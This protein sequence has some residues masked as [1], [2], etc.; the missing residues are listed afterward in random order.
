MSAELP[1]K[2]G[3]YRV[4]RELGRGATSRVLLATDPFGNREVAIKLFERSS[5]DERI[6]RRFRSM[7]LNEAMLA[8]K[9]SHPYIASIYDA[10]DDEDA[11]YI[12]MEYVPG[13]TLEYY[14]NVA[15]LLPV[16][17]VV[18]VVFKCAQ[19]LWFAQQRGL[20]HRD[21]KP[22]NILGNPDDGFKVSDFGSALSATSDQT[23]IS[24]IGSPAFMSP[25]QVRD[26]PLTHQ[27]D[28]YSLG[29]VMY[30]LL[31]GRLPFA[32]SSHASL[33]YQILNI[34]APPPSDA[35]EGL[36]EDIDAIVLRAMAKDRT[37]RYATWQDFADDLSRL[38]GT[39]SVPQEDLNDAAK[40]ARV[41]ELLFFDQFA[42]VEIWEMLRVTRW[43][44]VMPG[45]T[46]I[47][48]GEQGDSFYVL[49]DGE[50]RVSRG[51][52]TLNILRAGDC[53][54][55]MLYFN[56]PVARRT[57]TITALQ[58]SLVVEIKAAALNAASAA[59]Q[60]QVNR[61]FLRILLDRLTLAN[62]RLSS[63]A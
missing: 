4:L 24:G 56:A 6:A 29:V 16:P 42:E 26:E 25:E 3:K 46:L 36:P 17:Q 51:E 14:A 2:I 7:Y 22:A 48:E 9:L 38:T 15:T 39:I 35:R 30:Q 28:I 57:T 52:T 50:V 32:G 44:W 45:T 1:R 10:V 63:A 55:E 53:F 40:F 60:V 59:L 19:A 58:P 8:G 27:T 43:R 13:Q 37:R 31:T 21:I 12:V 47:R 41:R 34:D 33:A 5:S 20:I 61:A 54:G 62:A 11:S 23:Q 18:E 49:A